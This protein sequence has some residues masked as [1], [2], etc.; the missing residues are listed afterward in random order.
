MLLQCLAGANGDGSPEA[1]RVYIAVSNACVG[2]SLPPRYPVIPPRTEVALA[3][4]C[5]VPSTS[6]EHSRMNDAERGDKDRDT[7][8][9]CRKRRAQL[10][11]SVL[12]NLK[13][14][15][16]VPTGRAPILSRGGP[17]Q[18]RNIFVSQTLTGEHSS[19][20]PECGS[21]LGVVKALNHPQFVRARHACLACGPRRLAP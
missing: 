3:L 1:C 20:G 18:L 11:D 8:D 12:R 14:I 10:E 21:I 13:L 4:L 17:M 2:S 7:E 5:E 19:R 6:A 9:F 15:R 16:L